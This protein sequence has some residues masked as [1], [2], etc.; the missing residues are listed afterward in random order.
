MNNV[1]ISFLVAKS[2]SH[3]MLVYL[4]FLT[5]LS[6]V[7]KTD[8]VILLCEKNIISLPNQ[9]TEQGLSIPLTPTALRKSRLNNN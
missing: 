9:R 6:T 3:I 8:I 5:N 2:P 1:N 4:L 7:L